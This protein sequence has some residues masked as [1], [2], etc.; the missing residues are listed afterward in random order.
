LLDLLTARH[1]SLSDVPA[2][3]VVGIPLLATGRTP[4]QRSTWPIT[5]ASL[6]RTIARDPCAT[7][8]TLP[9]G[10]FRIDP[11]GDDP[12]VPG[13]VAG[14]AKDLAPQPEG[15]LSI[16]ASTVLASLGPEAAQM[17]E[18]QQGRP[19]CLGEIHDAPAQAMGRIFVQVA[20]LGPEGNVIR[21]PFG[22]DAG[23]A[24]VAGN[25]S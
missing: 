21:F 9:T 3:V 7:P 8:S 10:V 2:G 6:A 24:P 11:A 18:D 4:D 13:F 20:D 23:R 5:L 15:A 16:R 14:K 17:L 22:D 1:E 25:P 19:L 12:H